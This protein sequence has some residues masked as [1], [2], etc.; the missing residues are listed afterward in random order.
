[1]ENE[2]KCYPVAFAHDDYDA[3]LAGLVFSKTTIAAVAAHTAA[4]TMW[5]AT[6]AV[7]VTAPPP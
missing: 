1:M 6:A 3:T 4:T 5:T 7:V 2:G